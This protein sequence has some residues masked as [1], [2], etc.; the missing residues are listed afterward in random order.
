[1][2]IVAAVDRSGVKVM[3]AGDEVG[4]TVVGGGVAPPVSHCQARKASSRTIAV[5]ATKPAMS[6]TGGPGLTG[7]STAS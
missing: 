4:L 3:L 6:L 1:V 7:A 5:P 2:A